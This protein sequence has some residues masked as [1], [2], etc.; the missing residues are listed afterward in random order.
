[1]GAMLL[2]MLAIT[3][4]WLA[5][6]GAL[7]GIGALVIRLLDAR[8]TRHSLALRFWV[9]FAALLPALIVVHFF[10]PISPWLHWVALAVGWCSTLTLARAPLAS[11]LRCLSRGNWLAAIAWTAWLANRACAPGIATDAGSY[12]YPAIDWCNAF[13]VVPGLANFSPSQAMNNSSFLFAALLNAGPWN[14]RVEHVASG[15]LVLAAALMTLGPLERAWKRRAA[16]ADWSLVAMLPMLLFVSLGSEIATPDTD[17]PPGL[18]TLVLGH[19]VIRQFL[20]R[21]VGDDDPRRLPVL[22][23]LVAGL[24]TLKLSAGMFAALLALALVLHHARRRSWRDWLLPAGAGATFL[25]VVLALWVARGAMLSGFPL[26]PSGALPLAV[27]WRLPDDR[28]AYLQ[29]AISKTPRAQVPLWLSSVIANTPLRFYAPLMTPPF[30][31][32]A[33]VTA[34]NWIRPWLFTLPFTGFVELVLPL[35]LTTGLLV[36]AWRRSDLSFAALPLLA[37]LPIMLALWFVAS[38]D[39]RYVWGAAWFGVGAAAAIIAAG[40]NAPSRAVIV[41]L[42][43]CTLLPAIAYKS[44]VRLL[45]HRENPLRSIPF[46]LP[47]TD[48]GMHPRP[49]AVYEVWT[50]RHGVAVHLQTTDTLCWQGPLPRVGWPRPDPDLAYRRDGDLSAGFVIRRDQR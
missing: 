11:S 25:L 8:D 3:L 24:V 21:E 15:L 30:E 6:S 7:V 29:E 49:V 48:F 14:G 50:S 19:F 18:L 46:I 22:A 23:V 47:G 2:S 45:V 36:V 9:G 16:P 5:W 41:L 35:L 28:L 32:Y 26:Y 37:P 34:T 13:A 27:D 4:T 20:P 42:L 31:D 33:G 40:G 17:L 44:A 39:A 12:H 1:M 38:P 10:L 43:A